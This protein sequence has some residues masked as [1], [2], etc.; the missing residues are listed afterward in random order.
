M[1]EEQVINRL[2]KQYNFKCN[3]FYDSI[4][5]NST[6]RNWILEKQGEYYRLKHINGVQHKH[7]N[8]VHRKL[9]TNLDDAFKFINKHETQVVLDRDKS[10]RIKFDRLFEQIHK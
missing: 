3:I 2:S 5:I 1:F 7:K 8:H 10:K 6:Y 4:L 9:Y